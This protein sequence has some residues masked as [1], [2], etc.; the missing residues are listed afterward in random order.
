MII[1][2]I[3]AK[4]LEKEWALS[5]E[6]QH[7]IETLPADKKCKKAALMLGIQNARFEYILTTDADCI[8]SKN[9]VSSMVQAHISQKPGP[10][11]WTHSIP[12]SKK[13]D[14]SNL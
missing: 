6:Y 14:Y 12:I 1:P 3:I 9:W 8:H 10:H 4:I 11:R 2:K 5:L 13:Q 7:L